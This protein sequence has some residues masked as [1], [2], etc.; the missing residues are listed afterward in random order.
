MARSEGENV[1]KGA[2]TQ[3]CHCVT[4]LHFIHCGSCYRKAVR[5]LSPLRTQAPQNPCHFGRLG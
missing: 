5:K 3:I 1:A 2:A 4:F